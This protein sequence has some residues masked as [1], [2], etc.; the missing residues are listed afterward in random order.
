M[1]PRNCSRNSD[2][3]SR[4]RLSSPP[5]HRGSCLGRRFS[6]REGFSSFFPR[7]L[8][9]NW[10]APT[11]YKHMHLWQTEQQHRTTIPNNNTEQL[12]RTSRG[13]S[14]NRK[15]SVRLEQPSLLSRKLARES[16]P[17]SCAI[18]RILTVLR[19]MVR[20]MLPSCRHNLKHTT[21]LTITGGH[22]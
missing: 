17:H 14:E 7:R 6:S 21:S 19:I 2:P 12:Y 20:P 16:D 9:S 15:Y 4:S 1:V 22:S 13:A 3:G 8:A 5:P 18:T 10:S 11:G